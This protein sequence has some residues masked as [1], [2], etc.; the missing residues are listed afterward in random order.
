MVDSYSSFTKPDDD[1]L[2]EDDLPKKKRKKSSKKSE[3]SPKKKKKKDPNAPKKAL[4]AYMIFMSE[5]RERIK[6]ANPSAA[7]GEIV[8]F[9][10]HHLVKLLL[11]SKY[12][13]VSVDWTG[14]ARLQRIQ[15]P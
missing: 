1:D 8:S 5:N 10:I 3:G 11:A 2:I 7:F 14:K 15:K 6:E 13:H 9:F 12:L 4:S